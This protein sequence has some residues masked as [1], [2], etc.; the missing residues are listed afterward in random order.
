MFLTTLHHLLVRE[1]IDQRENDEGLPRLRLLDNLLDHAPRAEAERRGVGRA[2]PVEAVPEL[3][4]RALDRSLRG[5]AGAVRDDEDGLR[6]D[7][8]VVPV[9]LVVLVVLVL[10]AERGLGDGGAATEPHTAR[11]PVHHVAID[12]PFLVDTSVEGRLGPCLAE[13]HDHRGENVEPS[14]PR[15]I[16]QA[17]PCLRRHV[18]HPPRRQ[19]AEALGAA[20][21]G[22]GLHAEEAQGVLLR[23]HVGGRGQQA[24]HAVAELGVVVLRDGLQVVSLLTEQCVHLLLM[25]AAVLRQAFDQLPQQLKLP[26][27]EVWRQHLQRLL[28]ARLEVAQRLAVP[29]CVGPSIQAGEPTR[30]CARHGPLGLCQCLGSDELRSGAGDDGIMVRRNRPLCDG[31]S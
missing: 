18:L 23:Q 31:A 22:D 24:V 11:G 5:L 9:A 25:G 14:L 16:A 28:V 30:G 8:A 4:Q 6:D 13:H 17:L 7:G 21:A 26:C 19:K 29:P 1:G 10:I 2:R 20:E 15:V 27:V 12:R 3:P